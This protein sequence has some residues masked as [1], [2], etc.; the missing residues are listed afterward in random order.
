MLVGVLFT[1]QEATK[2]QAKVFTALEN[3]FGFTSEVVTT[4]EGDQT[5][6][7]VVIYPIE[8]GKFYAAGFRDNDQ[9][10]DYSKYKF[11][12]LLN[13]KKGSSISINVVD[14]NGIPKTVILDIPN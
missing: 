12:G 9:L 1:S 3:R 10:L 5:S 14:K 11:Y 8:N 7:V 6:H 13:E 2:L 4:N